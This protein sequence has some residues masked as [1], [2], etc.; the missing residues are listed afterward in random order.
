MTTSRARVF[1]TLALV[2]L[3][4]PACD[5]MGEP[6]PEPGID[7]L[8]GGCEEEIT[9]LAGVDASS[10]LGFSVAE[11][12]EVAV[13]EHASPMLWGA[14]LSDPMVTVEF[15][16]EAGEGKLTVDVAY[17]GGE[18]RYVKSTAK[19]GEEFDGG[20]QECFDRLEVD[21]DVHVASSG[22]AL[23]ESFSAPLQAM[24]P[25]IA[26]LSR[27]IAVDE[28]GG[29]LE[30]TKLEPENASVGPID[31][32]IGIT[33]DG[34]FGQAASTVEVVFED[35]I[36]ATFLTYASWPGGEGA[37][38]YGQAPIALGS[39][40]AGFSGA[41]VLDLVAK[42]DALE[43]TWGGGATTEL[44]LVLEHDGGWVCAGTQDGALAL[45]AMAKVGSGDGR[46]SGSFPVRVDG[47]P[48]ADGSLESA[49]V[50]IE[51]A[52]ANKVAVADF[53]A[54]YGLVGVDFTGFDAAIL[55]FGGE[56]TPV[57][58]GATLSG[59]YEVVGVV[60]NTCPPDANGCAGDDTTTLEIGPWGTP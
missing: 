49:S 60:S 30:I 44:A 22:G 8:D 48:G 24:I 11:V 43:I 51:A 54:T 57:G 59:E 20:Y 28:L 13:G 36:G 52:Y 29:S 4:A 55:S 21:V 15:G 39:A 47:R 3:V 23:D 2:A 32:N 35:V 7:S 40:A 38:D 33:A 18:V 19:G 25:R 26:T 10:P 31:L 42:A 34:L 16:P 17:N 14:G 1:A 37:C 58:E 56:V 9:I 12:L 6:T 5:L 46:W 41:D 27:R 45:R 50:Y 53:E